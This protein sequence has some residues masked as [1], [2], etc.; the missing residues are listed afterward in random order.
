MSLSDIVLLILMIC[1]V[2]AKVT[3]SV[4]LIKRVEKQEKWKTEENPLVNELEWYSLC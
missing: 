2:I 3:M 4:M 1:Q